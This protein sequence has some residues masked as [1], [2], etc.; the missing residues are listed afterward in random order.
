MSEFEEKSG[1]S[2]QQDETVPWLDSTEEVQF[3]ETGELAWRKW[4]YLLFTVLVVSSAILLLAMEQTR[5]HLIAAAAQQW[6]QIFPDPEVPA[7]E[8]AEIFVLPPPP[9]KRV[10]PKFV[11]SSRPVSIV[12]DPILYAEPDKSGGERKE[13][14]PLIPPVKT[15]ESR[16]AYDLLLERSQAVRKLVA[17]EYAEYR[18]KEWKLMRSNPPEFLINFLAVQSQNGKELHFIWSIETQHVKIRAL[19][20]AARDLVQREGS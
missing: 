19:S 1:E 17:N 3:S 11:M 5:Q 16:R 2:P 8:S 15:A 9:P 18:F 4:G 20:Q 12:E 13:E 14:K 7:V 10:E 6:M